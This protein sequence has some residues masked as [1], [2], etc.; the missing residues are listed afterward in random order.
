MVGAN[1]SIAWDAP[2]LEDPK[3]RRDQFMDRFFKHARPDQIVAII[4]ARVP[5]RILVSIGS[6]TAA[7]RN[8]ELKNQY[9]FYLNDENL[10]LGVAKKA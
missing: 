8:I 3:D 2:I 4:K 5:N 7:G 9:N 1:R 10:W 6:K